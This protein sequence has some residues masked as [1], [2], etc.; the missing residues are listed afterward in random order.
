MHVIYQSSKFNEKDI[1]CT[2]AHLASNNEIKFI[3]VNKDN[4]TIREWWTTIDKVEHANKLV[5]LQTVLYDEIY[6]GAAAK[7][8]TDAISKRTRRRWRNRS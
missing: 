1:C 2:Y 3:D 6:P 5:R 8:V 7:I 4:K